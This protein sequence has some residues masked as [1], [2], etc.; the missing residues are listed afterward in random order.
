MNKK[1]LFFS[2]IA[3]LLV[4]LMI[5]GFAQKIHVP[6]NSNM[7]VIERRVLIVNEFVNNLQNTYIER[8]IRI[9][10]IRTLESIDELGNFENVLIK[11]STGDENYALNNSLKQLSITAEKELNIYS[12]L[13]PIKAIISQDE[14]TGPWN[15]KVN[16][17]LSIFVDGDVAV[18][19]K[20]TNIVSVVS[21]IGLDDPLYSRNQFENKIRK[22]RDINGL[23]QFRLNLDDQSYNFDSLAPSYLNRFSGEAASE[24]CGIESY[25]NPNQMKLKAKN[26]S[27]VDY[28]YFKNRCIQGPYGEFI[29]EIDSISSDKKNEEY[30][31]FRLDNY[32]IQKL[33]LSDD[34]GESCKYIGGNEWQDDPGCN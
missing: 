2:A 6:V 31:G 21:I 18:W 28:C 12:N 33:N 16:L 9:G 4:G 32:H 8:L 17:T 27:Y 5:I 34:S 22:G 14:D 10:T 7:P 1:G 3:V 19:N 13:T 15:V 11:G 23:N 25:L 30:F 29:F 26:T 20:T 24:C